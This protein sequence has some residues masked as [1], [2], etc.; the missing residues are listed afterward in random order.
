MTAAQSK[1]L[2]QLAARMAS[3]SRWACV[4]AAFKLGLRLGAQ[5]VLGPACP[6]SCGQEPWHQRGICREGQ[7]VI[8]RQWQAAE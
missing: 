8:M 7:A 4:E 5:E 1:A 3:A 6:C 2:E